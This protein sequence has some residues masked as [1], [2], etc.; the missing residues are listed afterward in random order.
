VLELPTCEELHKYI[1]TPEVCTPA[2]FCIALLFLFCSVLELPTCEEE[3]DM[4]GN[5][6][7][8]GLQRHQPLFDHAVILLPVTAVCWS[9]RPVKKSAT[10]TTHTP[11]FYNAATLDAV[12][13]TAVPSLLCSVL[14]LPT[15][16]QER[17]M[18]G[19]VMFRG[20]L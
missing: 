14:E 13:R 11:D 19:N 1:C 5:V 8:R 16:E 2:L 15:C 3:R 17:D 7:F 6:M 18:H 10:C 20:P 12:C 4:H 9:C